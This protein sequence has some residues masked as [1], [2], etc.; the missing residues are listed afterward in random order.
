MD[1]KNFEEN[2]KVNLLDDTSK[3]LN[4]INNNK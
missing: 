4:I 2:A 3:T 1:M